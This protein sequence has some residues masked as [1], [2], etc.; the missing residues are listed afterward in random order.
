MLW[1]DM[2]LL[3]L[4]APELAPVMRPGQFALFRDPAAF[5]P[6]LRRTAW[7]YRIGSGRVAFTLPA[8]DP[9][10]A[11]ARP[12]D[13]LDA[14]APLGRAIEFDASARRILLVGEGARVAPL[15][16]IAD[17]AVA[18][19]REVVLVS[20]SGDAFPS[21]LLA[22]E[23][24]YRADADALSAELIAWADALVASGSSETYRALADVARAARYRIK[25][26]WARVLIDL[27][28]PC[29]VGEC[30]A[31]AVETRR[32]VQRACVDGPAFDL[33]DLDRRR[34]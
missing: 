32:G 5:D 16:A 22:P 23:I 11:R 9:L 34:G 29:G 10:A 20:R 28:M 15:I 25:P 33:S 4:D 3:T 7:F 26:G 8:R 18:Q 24:E 17:R 2:R 1:S 14:R 21:H 13:L 6:Y 12:G 31:C 30:Y 27:P 19:Q